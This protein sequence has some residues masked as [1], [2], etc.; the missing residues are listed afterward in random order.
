MN[1]ITNVEGIYGIREIEL[2]RGANEEA[3]LYPQMFTLSV[4]L[5]F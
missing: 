3:K 1:H 5:Q 2:I 4:E